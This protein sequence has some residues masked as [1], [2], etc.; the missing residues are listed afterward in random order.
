[1]P[2][3]ILLCSLFILCGILL[4]LIAPAGKDHP[5]LEHIRSRRIAH[6]GLH[7]APTGAPEN[8]LAA[9]RLARE[10]GL[11]IEIDLHLT[12][13]GKLVVIHDE[14]TARVC[15][16]DL[17]VEKSTLQELRALS[18]SPDGEK[19]PTLEECLDCIDGRVP[20]LIEYKMVKGNTD[21]LCRAA[22]EIL[23]R[24]SGPYLIQ[25][26]FPQILLWYRKNRPS[27]CR[28]QLADA[29]PIKKIERFLLGRML[30]NFIG[31]PHFISYGYQNAKNPLRRAVARLGAFQAGWTFPSEEEIQRHEKDFSAFIFD[32]FRP[33]KR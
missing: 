22:E 25:S 17:N 3:V 8:S 16:K 21:A 14:N 5:D 28:G 11:A 2:L 33:K 9:F 6:R 20:L 19:I 15:G 18:L 27:V 26:F 29:F 30:F 4:F 32:G 12:L 31:R 13:D 1:M 10:A 23:S 24:Y 7:G